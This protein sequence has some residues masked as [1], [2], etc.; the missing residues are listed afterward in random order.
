MIDVEVVSGDIAS[1]EADALITTVNREG[2]WFGGIDT[3][4]QRVAGGQFH[5]LAAEAVR[6]G[7]DV[8]KVVA[9]KVADHGG[10]F[11]DVI[12]VFDELDVEIGRRVI[13]ALA[14]AEKAGYRHV[15][16]PA[17]RL[18]AMKNVGWSVEETVGSIVNGIMLFSLSAPVSVEQPVL[19]KITIVVYND[20][21]LRDN[22]AG[23]IKSWT[24]TFSKP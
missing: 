2:L 1:I 24:E 18:G 17:L 14:A 10:K 23:R 5:V 20:P 3:V 21:E 11:S 6:E 4:I 13:S 7:R 9:R 8:D 22:F 15:T 19:E 12:F 16:M